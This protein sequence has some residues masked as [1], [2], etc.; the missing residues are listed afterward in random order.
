MATAL[1]R[2]LERLYGLPLGEF[3]AARNDLAKRLRADGKTDDAEQV[4]A[5]K[6]PS[7][8]VW[9]ANQLV[10]HDEVDVQRLL[11]AGETLTRTQ[12]QVAGGRSSDEFLEARREEHR[13]LE[14]LARVAR[15]LAA[16][17]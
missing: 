14:Q 12:A 13:A 7:V 17:Q 16:Q 5:L 3:T 10:H 2:E 15:S 1:E 8:A 6:K 11:K 4:K 9:L